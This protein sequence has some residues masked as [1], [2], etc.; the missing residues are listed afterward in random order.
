MGESPVGNRRECMDSSTITA[1]RMDELLKLHSVWV[2]SYSQSPSSPVGKQLVLKGETVSGIS[3]VER[4]FSSSQLIGCVFCDSHFRDC[5]FSH[6]DLIDGVFR[7][8]QFGSCQFFK[9]DLRACRCIGTNFS[10][11][12]FTRAD[13]TDA[14][15]SST[16]LTGSVFDSAWLVRTDLRL[17][18]LEGVQFDRA[19]L[20]NTKLYN[21]RRF[22]IASA[23]DVVAKDIDFSPD[24]DGSMRLGIE[25]LRF[26][27]R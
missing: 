22:Q 16:D 14:V 4:D 15:M 26:I 11:C 6:A 20:A 19:R 17:A 21:D 3:F 2:K 10:K 18:V 5:D 9:A 7:E 8:C 24:A 1:A 25:A 13:L 27:Q 23:A 12:D